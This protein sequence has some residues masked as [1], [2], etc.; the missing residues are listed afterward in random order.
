MA[1]EDLEEVAVD[2]KFSFINFFDSHHGR[3]T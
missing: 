3:T 2:G 1:A